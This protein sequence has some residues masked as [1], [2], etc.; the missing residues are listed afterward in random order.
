MT[1][2]GDQICFEAFHMDKACNVQTD[3]FEAR[4]L[5]KDLK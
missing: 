3:H 4:A 5:Q 2:M 1:L